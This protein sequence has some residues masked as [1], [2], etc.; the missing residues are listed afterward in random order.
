MDC[1]NKI[2]IKTEYLKKRKKKE[3]KIYY[4]INYSLLIQTVNSAWRLM[5]K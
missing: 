2:D 1:Y 5:D 3:Y 4:I